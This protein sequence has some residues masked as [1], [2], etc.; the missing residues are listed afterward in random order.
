MILEKLLL[1]N[2]QGVSSATETESYIYI[3]IY[4]YELENMVN[5][6]ITL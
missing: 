6:V 1:L 4:I 3:Y 5:V 2:F